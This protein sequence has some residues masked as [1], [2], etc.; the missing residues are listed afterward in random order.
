MSN[1]ISI[2]YFSCGYCKNKM[3]TI[4]KSVIKNNNSENKGFKQENIKNQRR[5]YAKENMEN[6]K[7]PKG[8]II[9]PAGVFLIRHK[10][11]GYILYDT[12][13]S[14]EIMK[15]KIKYMIY[16]APN[17]VT[18]KGEDE[19]CYQL[20]EKG[21]QRRDINYIIL[22][23]L[24]PDHI[25][26]AKNFPNARFIVTEDC[27]KDYTKKQIFSLIFREF[28]PDDLEKRLIIIDKYERSKEF[29]FKNVNDLFKDR[30]LYLTS[31]NG[32]AK[33][34]G[35]LFIPEKNL[36]IGADV[37]WGSELLDFT[38]NMK[39]VSRL[40]QDNFEEYRKGIVILKELQKNGIK[41]VVSH[42]PQERIKRVLDE[43]DN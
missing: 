24:H 21:I 42:D 8:E 13:Y 15:N 23:H 7:L 39:I 14:K 1:I 2:D 12:G 25:G 10:V 40:I 18:V 32:H 35:C 41:V 19:I 33:G 36:F 28:L 20:K 16:R 29:P 31:I 43:K 6:K 11:Y 4:F 27:H 38:D 9:F 37:S 5:I 34:Q 3:E 22:S 30:S 26:G 17:P